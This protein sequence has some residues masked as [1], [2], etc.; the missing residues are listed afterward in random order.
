MKENVRKHL[1]IENHRK[2]SAAS[3]STI[4]KIL[5]SLFDDEDIDAKVKKTPLYYEN[6]DMDSDDTTNDSDTDIDQGRRQATCL[7]RSPT[8]FRS[9]FQQ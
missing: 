5:R 2:T 7:R 8:N 9:K 1:P 6:D 4:I 3:I